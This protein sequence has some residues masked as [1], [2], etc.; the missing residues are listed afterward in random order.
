MKYAIVAFIL[1]L[2]PAFCF[3]QESGATKLKCQ[4]KF[5]DYSKANIRNVPVSGIYIEITSTRVKVSGAPA[6]E[7]TYS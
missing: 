6:F 7:A 3:A 1:G 4:G 2:L 5:D